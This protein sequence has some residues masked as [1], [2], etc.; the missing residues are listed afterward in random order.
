MLKQ[1]KLASTVAVLALGAFGAPAMAASSAFP[2]SEFNGMFWSPEM[3][4]RMDANKD[5]M[6]SRD[7]F[8]NYMGRQ[9]DM[10]DTGKKKM[11][12]ATQFTDKT[13]MSKTF[14]ASAGE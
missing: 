12:T 3:M 4:K 11:L 8:M 13:M 7:E 2:Q 9:Y 1:L 6:V 14:P 5:G 10:M